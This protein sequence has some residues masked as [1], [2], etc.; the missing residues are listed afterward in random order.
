MLLSR[1]DAE[2]FF[3]LHC[4]LMQ[5]VMEQVHGVG[6]PAS[7]AAYRSLPA[8]ERHQLAQAFLGRLDLIDVFLKTNPAKLSEEELGMVS[9]WRHL[10]AGRFV[11]LRQLKQHM[12]LL[13]CGAE[14]TAYGVKGLVDPIDLVIPNPLPAMI[15][16]VLLPFRGQ[17]IYGSSV[18]S[19]SASVQVPGAVSRKIFELPRRAR[20]L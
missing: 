19:I 11:A 10:V 3:K 14:V 20:A 18:R 17:I 8:A 16:T 12:V 4:A 1:E 15:E 2:L 6:V 5:F 7:P 9:S 13:A